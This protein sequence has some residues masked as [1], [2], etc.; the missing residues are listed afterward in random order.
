MLLV[1]FNGL[2]VEVELI[3][4][5]LLE[6]TLLDV[7]LPGPKSLMNSFSIVEYN[8]LS[9]NSKVSFLGNLSLVYI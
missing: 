9:D 6:V 1:K 3:D 8:F 2:I 5:V 7:E 4:V